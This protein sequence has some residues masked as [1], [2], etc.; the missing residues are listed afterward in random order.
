VLDSSP[1]G[2]DLTAA[3]DPFAGPVTDLAVLPGPGADLAPVPVVGVPARA[4]EG[5][6]DVLGALL[7]D[8]EETL[9]LVLDGAVDTRL[10]ADLDEIL[11][12][13][14]VSAVRHVV[15]EMATVTDLDAAGL[16]F[17]LRVQDLVAERGGTVR[18]ADPP[19]AV[20]DV[21]QGC[22]AAAV[23]GL[24]EEPEARPA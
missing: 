24:T 13:I 2:P 11:A 17:L 22:G 8:G 16:R 15:V 5:P 14:R 4:P 1:L 19:D 23:L 9:S 20:R 12:S 10:S 7:D 3:P 18:L 6:H 21:V